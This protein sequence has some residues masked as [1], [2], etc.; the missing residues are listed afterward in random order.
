MTPSRKPLHP[1]VQLSRE[2]GPAPSGRLSPPAAAASRNP[3]ALAGRALLGA[4][5][6]F[7]GVGIASATKVTLKNGRVIEGIVVDEA[8]G[9]F[10]VIRTT[11]SELKLKSSDIKF[12][13]RETTAALEESRG[14]QAL[15]E[16][17]LEEALAS[18]ALVKKA[19]EGSP[20]LER[21]LE[22]VR[23]QIETRDLADFAAALQSTQ[24]L[25]D[26]GKLGEAQATLEK[27]RS[28]PK[29]SS[30]VVERANSL[31]ARV[32]F[33]KAQKAI[34][35]VNTQVAERELALSLEL[36][37]N[38]AAARVQLGDLFNQR[39]TGR[40]RALEE[41]KKGLQLGNE[42]L[43]EKEKNRIRWNI[44]RLSM[45]MQDYDGAIENFKA[46]Y[47]SAPRFDPKLVEHL[48]ESHLRL[49]EL[50]ARKEPA[51][52]ETAYADALRYQPSDTAVRLRFA[53]FLRERGKFVECLAQVQ[54]AL[55]VNRELPN[56][57][58]IAAQCLQQTGKILEAREHLEAEIRINP[59]NYNAL[60]DLADLYLRG[61][62][63][64]KARDYFTRAI[65]SKSEAGFRAQLGAGK[66]L[67]RLN[68]RVN[69]RN[70]VNNVLAADPNNREANLEMGS[71]LKE[72]KDYT[73]SQ[74]YFDTV[75][76]GLEQRKDT[77]NA[78]E[79]QLLADAF[80]RRGEISLLLQKPRTAR[81]DFEE[82][83]KFA[84]TY[85]LTY[86]NIGLSYVKESASSETGLQKAEENYKKAREMGPQ[87]PEFALGLGIFYHQTRAQVA[88]LPADKKK[89]YLHLA[90]ENYMEYVK[91]GGADPNVRQWIIELGGNPDK[92][93]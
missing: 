28:T 41:Y 90:L 84:P 10:I 66:V 11:T 91:L 8:P 44:A 70:H 68:D 71:I 45:E 78:D 22:R 1:D 32:H 60:C 55:E 31:L 64:L 16:G 19:K 63:L 5:L 20:D 4:T 13:D 50:S 24:R 73:G 61:G 47:A 83:L 40:K 37:P 23:R 65:D 17:R 48:V 21:K 85:A 81:N 56:A 3:W 35:I 30:V 18:Y 43:D 14:D 75:I 82:A 69:A 54:A 93:S 53:Q 89:E 77:L 88:N 36:D 57:N 42:Q 25:I 72:E 39:R 52:A 92:K 67:R 26:D 7:V 46:V 79:R 76:K 87:S 29:I 15:Q 9:E 2:D 34:D 74:K 38:Y 33:L 27:L 51:K 49:A 12:V 58:Y 59:S 80:N 6:L 62:D 86:A